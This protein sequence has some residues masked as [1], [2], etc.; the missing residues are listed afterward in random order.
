MI[1]S[2]TITLT[3][4]DWT[5]YTEK[6]SEDELYVK[7]IKR[8][9]YMNDTLE[10]IIG[11]IYARDKDVYKKV[12]KMISKNKMILRFD[13]VNEY[14][15]KNGIKAVY[16]SVERIDGRIAGMLFKDC[17]VYEMKESIM[18]GIEKWNIVAE[19]S[20]FMKVLPKIRE[21]TY[22]F[23]VVENTYDPI[24]SI[25]NELTHKEMEILKLAVNKGFFD[26]PKR[27]GLEELAEELGVS[28]SAIMQILRKAMAKIAKKTV[29]D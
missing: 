12:L 19:S 23:K 14:K 28:K 2:Y 6:F 13:L 10:N 7:V 26:T 24:L 29:F 20:S 27:V 18:S 8:L 9:P 11:I 16:A 3:H 21:L 1:K 4:D 15:N 5:L 17:L 25:Q 22:E